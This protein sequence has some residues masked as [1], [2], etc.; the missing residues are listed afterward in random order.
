MVSLVFAGVMLA[1][2]C[3]CAAKKE[4]PAIIT[5]GVV[6]IGPASDFPAGTANTRFLGQYGIVVTNESGTPL[7]IRP[8]CPYDLA[9]V[10][11]NPKI[12]QFECPAHGCRYD[13]L[14]RVSGGP[15][16]KP[17][18]GVATRRQADGTL[19]VDLSQLYGM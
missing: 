11:W 6:N 16:T 18:A 1:V 5:S 4:K 19:T 17:L 8:Q 15:S 3:A 7:A 9:T 13:L 10:R 14:G 2:L 12:E